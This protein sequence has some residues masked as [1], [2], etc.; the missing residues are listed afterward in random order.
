MPWLESLCIVFLSSPC[1]YWEPEP[2]LYIDI[3]T[4][5]AP[6]LRS[7]TWKSDELHRSVFELPWTRLFSIDVDTTMSTCDSVDILLHSHLQSLNIWTDQ[8]F[9]PFFHA[10]TLPT[11][12]DVKISNIGS[13]GKPKIWSSEQ[14]SALILRS[15]CSLRSLDLSQI[16]RYDTDLVECLID[17]TDSLV[18]LRIISGNTILF[19]D[20][21]LKVLTMGAGGLGQFGC[22]CPKLEVIRLCGPFS[23]SAVAA[24]V[25]S[26]PGAT[27]TSFTRRE[28]FGLVC[29]PAKSWSGIGWGA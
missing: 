19:T 28:S 16:L 13:G 26:R 15:S 23:S 10:L 12:R 11:L 25:E 9:G 18:E 5:S 6:Q 7:F 20:E 21:V 1:D 27:Q 3:G 17:T 2:G 29:G 4:E 8:P 14:F 22:L 24:M